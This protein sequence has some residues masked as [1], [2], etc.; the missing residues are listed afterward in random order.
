MSDLSFES[1]SDMGNLAVILKVMRGFLSMSTKWETES[2]VDRV[3]I[4][5]YVARGDR[6]S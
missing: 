5:A 1:G 6:N 3:G 4:E 2:E